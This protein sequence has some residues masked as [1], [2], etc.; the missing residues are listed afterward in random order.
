MLDDRPSFLIL[1]KLVL[2]RFSCLE[3]NMKLLFLL[4]RSESC[5]EENIA[6]YEEDESC[7]QKSKIDI[8]REA[9]CF[10]MVSAFFM[11]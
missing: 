9:F 2:L 4:L 3:T 7:F 11:F 8:S 10:Q 6:T 1:K 5:N